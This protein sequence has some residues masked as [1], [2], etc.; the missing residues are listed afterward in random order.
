M[1]T[2]DRSLEPSEWIGQGVLQG[3]AGGRAEKTIAGSRGKSKGSGAAPV[4]APPGGG[5][6]GLMASRSQRSSSKHSPAKRVRHGAKKGAGN[7]A[8]LLK[9]MAQG[10]GNQAVQQRL[11]RAGG[12]RDE[13]LAFIAERL[14][15][16]QRAQH[17]ESSL[18]KGKDTWWREAARNRPEVWSPEPERWG[19]VAREYREAIDA[20][21]RGDL[22]RGA[23]LLERA[24]ASER[25]AIDAMPRGLGLHPEE[26]SLSGDILHGPEAGDSIGDGEGCTACERP[27]EELRVA[28]EIER[29]SH[30]ARP[31]RGLRIAPAGTP[32]W[33]EEEEEEE[34]EEG[35]G[36]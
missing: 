8:E 7:Q 17:Q 11:K 22:G 35:E 31:L 29:F 12:K 27:K 36:A 23:R 25:D 3:L 24:M 30:T 20:L 19:R 15:N 16:I 5:Y 26:G 2:D 9:A 10:L 1:A 4:R 18:L 33:E 6:D 28:A 34:E 14:R 13:L 32:W 21:C